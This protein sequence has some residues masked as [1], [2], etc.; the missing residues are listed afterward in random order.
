MSCCTEIRAIALFEAL[1]GFDRQYLG[2]RAMSDSRAKETASKHRKLRVATV[3]PGGTGYSTGSTGSGYDYYGSGEDTHSWGPHAPRGRGRDSGR[4]RG[5]VITDH[6]TQATLAAHWDELLI[7]ALKTATSLLP[8]PY[9]EDAQVYDMLPHSST[10]QLLQTSQLPELLASLLRNDSITDWTERSD[11]YNAMLLLL[12][13]MADC[14]L[15]LEVCTFQH[16]H[17][18]VLTDPSSGAHR[19]EIQTR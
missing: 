18:C 12:R 10:A 19:R 17:K 3:G 7:R 1:G 8:A 2:E 5:A 6:S 15:T 14:E 9:A 13:R 16:F 4:G 11:L